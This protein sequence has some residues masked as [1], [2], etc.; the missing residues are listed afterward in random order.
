MKKRRVTVKLLDDAIDEYKKL[1]RIVKE[2]KIKGVT[3]SPYQTLLKGINDK[4]ELLK[5]NCEA[6]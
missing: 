1:N 5:L 4:I 2:E 6:R 3:G